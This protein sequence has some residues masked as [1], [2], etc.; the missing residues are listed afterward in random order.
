MNKDKSQVRLV[1]S[2]GLEV[3]YRDKKFS[4]LLCVQT[5]PSKQGTGGGVLDH[6]APVLCIFLGLESRLFPS[7]N[8]L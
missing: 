1:A 3:L 7:K 2:E 5:F 6:R 4:P 8:N